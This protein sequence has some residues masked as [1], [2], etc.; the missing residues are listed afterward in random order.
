MSGKNSRLATK[1]LLISA[2]TIVFGWPLTVLGEAPVGRGAKELQDAFRAVVKAVKPAVVNVSAVKHI[3]ARQQVPAIDPFFENH[4]FRE[5]FGDE[6][7]RRF[8]QVPGETRK[9]KQ[10]GLASG[11]LFDSRG[12]IL[13]NRHAIK[14]ADE[15]IVTVESDKKFKARIIGAD[16]K[17]DVAVLKIDGEAF[18]YAKLG[19]PRTLE[20]GDWVLAIGNPFGLMKTVTAGIV[21]AVGRSQMGILDYEDFI[22]TDAAINPGNSGGPLVNIEGQVVGINTAIVSR[23]GGNMG[24][25]FAIPI[26]VVKK[27]AD[28]AMSRQQRIAP[29]ARTGGNLEQPQSESPD[30]VV[31]RL[32]PSGKQ[33]GSGI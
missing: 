28:V 8:F 12:Y 17:T 13:T 22:Q 1:M 26:D 21:S 11:V 33:G 3:T 18:P 24:I 23:S 5:F 29:K 31:D 15:I 20:V 10:Q 30:M 14:D 6:F 32:F 2:I 9:F 27:I 25:G 7:F 19:D 4:P 16:P